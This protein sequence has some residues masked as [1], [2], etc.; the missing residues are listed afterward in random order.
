MTKMITH[1]PFMLKRTPCS[2]FLF[3]VLL[4][5]GY[6]HSLLAQEFYGE[7]IQEV[8]LELPFSDWDSKLDS[9]KNVKPFREAAWHCLGKWHSI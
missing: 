3:V 1:S 6:S 8:R 4:F 7:G 9:M 5:S 2:L